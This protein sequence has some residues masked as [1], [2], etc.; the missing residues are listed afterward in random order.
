MGLMTTRLQVGDTR[1]GLEATL[2]NPDG[3]P[4]TVLGTTVTFRMRSSVSREVLVSGT[5]VLVGEPGKVRYDWAPGDTDLA[6]DYEA[7]FVV[8]DGSGGISSYP[9][10]AWHSVRIEP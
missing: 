10:S 1:P 2:V 9:N 3:T 5:A 6:G 4:A 8:D 7:R